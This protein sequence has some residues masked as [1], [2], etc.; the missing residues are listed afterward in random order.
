VKVKCE[1]KTRDVKVSRPVLVSKCLQTNFWWSQSLCQWF[2]S[3]SQSLWSRYWRS[4]LV[5]RSIIILLLSVV[6]KPFAEM[7]EFLIK[8]TRNRFIVY[9]LHAA[10][11]DSC[12]CHGHC[13][14]FLWRLLNL[15][16]GNSYGDHI[17][18]C[19]SVPTT[20]QE[21]AI[22]VWKTV[23]VTVSEFVQFSQWRY[24]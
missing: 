9:A 6:H 8:K 3:W 11:L 14:H 17:T 23:N 24:A 20:T 10:I 19:K 4:G 12:T 13:R 21:T 5:S 16:C 2:R 15:V 7:Q 1:S 22:C 18:V